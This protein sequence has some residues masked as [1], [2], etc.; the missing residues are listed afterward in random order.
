MGA[1]LEL[2]PNYFGSKIRDAFGPYKKIPISQLLEVDTK[3]REPFKSVKFPFAKF[4]Y[5]MMVVVAVLGFIE[6]YSALSNWKTEGRESKEIIADILADT[7]ITE[8]AQEADVESLYNVASDGSVPTTTAQ[9]KYGKDYW[10]YTQVP[11]MSVNFSKLKQTNP[12]TVGWL[13]VNNTNINYPFVQTTDN[14]YYLDHSFNKTY[15]KAGWLFADFR[16]DLNELKRN[17]VIYAHGRTDKVL[18][19]SLQNVLTESWYT[20]RD[21]H[22]IKVSTPDRNMLFQVVSVYTVKA[23]SYY[24]TH[25]FEN[26]EAYLKYL[27]TIQGRSKYDF[28]V[29]LD[30]DDKILTLST[31]L[32][33]NG[34]RIVLHARLAKVSAR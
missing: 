22:I 4:G 31:C 28:G 20:N 16:S 11:M 23:E 33:S 3:I 19:G 29:K 1:T 12:D 15:T 17:T 30:K 8:E 21:N 34:N 25:N 2:S 14:S 27:D 24:L 13:Y 9:Y 18:F 26:D 10:D 6:C 5:M 7:E 32:D